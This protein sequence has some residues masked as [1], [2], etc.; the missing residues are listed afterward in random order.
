MS[1]HSG[2]VTPAHSQLLPLKNPHTSTAAHLHTHLLTQ[3][4]PPPHTQGRRLFSL[5]LSSSS[6]NCVLWGWPEL[7]KSS[8]HS[9]PHLQMP[10]FIGDPGLHIQ[11]RAG[12]IFSFSCLR[13]KH[14]KRE[15]LKLLSFWVWS[16]LIPLSWH[17]HW[18]PLLGL[19]RYL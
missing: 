2:D 13:S 3:P 12:H 8:R 10:Q 4:S 19:P 5:S 16:L 18:Q 6:Y 15:L 7:W 14:L 17:S 11:S 9:L 1:L